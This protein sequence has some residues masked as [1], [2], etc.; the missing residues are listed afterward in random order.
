MDDDEDEGASEANYDDSFC[1]ITFKGAAIDDVF[2]FVCFLVVLSFDDVARE[3]DAFKVKDREI[4]IFKLVSC[5]VRDNVVL[6]SNK[7]S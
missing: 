4:V 7:V 5:V 2:G 3:D 6:G 1:L